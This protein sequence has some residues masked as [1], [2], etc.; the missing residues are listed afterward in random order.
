MKFDPHFLFLYLSKYSSP[1]KVLSDQT[2]M[3]ELVMKPSTDQMS[4]EVQRITLEEKKKGRGRE[5]KEGIL[6]SDDT[7]LV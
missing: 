2:K 7:I 5:D 3:A 1:I 6:I 4:K